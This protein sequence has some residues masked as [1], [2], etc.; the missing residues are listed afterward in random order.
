MCIGLTY[1]KSQFKMEFSYLKQ[2]YDIEAASSKF[3]NCCPSVASC[4]FLVFFKEMG[5]SI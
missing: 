5:Q 1:F 4:E 3:S 2:G